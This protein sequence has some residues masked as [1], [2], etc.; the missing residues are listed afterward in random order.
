MNSIKIKRALKNNK[1]IFQNILGA[2]FVKGGS[3]LVSFLTMPAYI[4]YFNNQTV[5]GLWFTILSVLNWVFTFD[6]GL[7]N[8]LRNK[9]AFTMSRNE[10]NKAK[11]YISSAYVL[12]GMFTIF[13]CIISYFIFPLIN[14]NSFFNIK[15]NIVDPSVLLLSVRIIFLGIMIQFFLKLINSVLYAMQKSALNNFLALLSNIIILLYVLLVPGVSTNENLISLSYV[16]I[17]AVNLPLLIASIVVFNTSLKECKPNILKYSSV[18]AKSIFHVGIIFFVLQIVTIIIGGTN[19]FLISKFINPKDVVEYQIY[20][21]IF[22][23]F[24][25]IYNLAITPLW[26]AVTKAEGEG[27]Y[28]WIIKLHKI[29]C[30]ISFALGGLLLI[31]IPFVQILANVWL[32][33]STIQISWIYTLIFAIFTTL[34]IFNGSNCCIANG[35]SLLKAQTI[36]LVLGGLINIPLAYIFAKVTGLW[37]S[38]VLA[39]IFSLL[40]ICI[41]Q[42]IYL[43]RQLTTRK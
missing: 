19:E 39:N 27:K 43:H 24:N 17:I 1:I 18:Y 35:M 4:R 9:L 22:G 32:G 21:K 26:S 36:F 10:K 13:I 28:L 20:N 30:I 3:M 14:W 6:L 34:Q 41:A 15:Q 12:V 23:L 5:L 29:L 7:G 2:F 25:S 31:F 16:N 33:K 37:I 40:P 42:P 38:I 8:G 11:N